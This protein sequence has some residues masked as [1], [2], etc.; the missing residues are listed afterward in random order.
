MVIQ[1]NFLRVWIRLCAGFHPSAA[2]TKAKA[3]GSGYRIK[4]LKI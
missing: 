1:D 4:L 3:I 2:N